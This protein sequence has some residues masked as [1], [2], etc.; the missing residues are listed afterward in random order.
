MGTI[1]TAM[2]AMGW[3]SASK[4]PVCCRCDHAGE[5]GMPAT[6]TWY[7]KKGGFM[8]SG[9]AVCDEFKQRVRHG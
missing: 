1:K 4:R 2:A 6:P 7:C 3:Q 9:Q 8:T 5:R